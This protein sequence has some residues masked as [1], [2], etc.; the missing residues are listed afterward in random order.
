[1]FAAVTSIEKSE[2][3]CLQ[4][5]YSIDN[6]MLRPPLLALKTY[7]LDACSR[8]LSA[9]VTSILFI[10]DAACVQAL[11]TFGLDAC[12]RRVALSAAL[13]SI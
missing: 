7:G 1:M 4:P 8:L 12:G 3:R 10:L 13:T 11:K 6:Y 5:K 2:I 9:A